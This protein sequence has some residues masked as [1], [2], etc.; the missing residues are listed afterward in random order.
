MKNLVGTLL[1]SYGIFYANAW[2]QDIPKSI[3]YQ[4]VL[5]SS[6]GTPDPSASRSLTFNLYDA[7]ENLIWGPYSCPDTPL[8]NGKFHVLLGNVDEDP[9]PRNLDEVLNANGEVFIGVSVDEGAEIVPRQKILS[10]P[11]SLRA[12]VADTAINATK[13]VN[14][15]PIG[16]IVM[17]WGILDSPG[18][19]ICDGRI[20]TDIPVGAV[21]SD[22]ANPAFSSLIFHLRSIGGP[23]LGPNRA[24]L[25]DFR[26]M[27]PRGLDASGTNVPLQAG[28]T[29]GSFEEEQFKEHNHNNGVFRRLMVRREDQGAN[30][31]GTF[32]GRG[33]NSP[34]DEPLLDRSQDILAAG[35]AET[36]P[37]NIAV[38]FIISYR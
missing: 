11:F 1:I 2:S 27:F 36:R 30:I 38:N 31:S 25:P 28:R 29:I 13:A 8:A 26:G 12:G 14:A 10:V 21:P 20:I 3:N 7:G 33:D 9:S 24:Q 35:G 17:Y 34:A 6:D 32:S 18:W 5:T 23:D 4:G 15:G 37:K 19:L 16:T 22:L